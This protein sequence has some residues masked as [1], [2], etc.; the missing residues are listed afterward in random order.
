M[1][2][3]LMQTKLYDNSSKKYFEQKWNDI[4]LKSFRNKNI[5]K[6]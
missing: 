5:S 6:I 4:V 2:Y 3:R 1:L